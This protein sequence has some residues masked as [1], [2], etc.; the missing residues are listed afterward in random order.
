MGDIGA[1]RSGRRPSPIVGK[2]C[3]WW[4]EL[5]ETLRGVADSSRPEIAVFITLFEWLTM[6]GC[7]YFSNILEF[8][9]Y[10]HLVYAWCTWG[11]QFL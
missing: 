2:K 5:L 4:K 7:F 8:I 6:L 9:G 11:I 1:A 3:L 10:V